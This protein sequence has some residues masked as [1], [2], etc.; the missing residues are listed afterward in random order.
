MCGEISKDS[1]GTSGP[2]LC[3]YYVHH[4]L[5]PLVDPNVQ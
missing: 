2:Y 5:I 1:L 4:P 3:R